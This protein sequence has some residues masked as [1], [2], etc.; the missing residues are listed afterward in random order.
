MSKTDQMCKEFS[1]EQNYKQIRYLGRNQIYIDVWY[2]VNDDNLNRFYFIRLFQQLKLIPKIRTWSW[3]PFQ[4]PGADKNFYPDWRSLKDIY[5]WPE[6]AARPPPK[7][8]QTCTMWGAMPFILLCCEAQTP[9]FS[10]NRP[11]QP[12][13]REKWVLMRKKKLHL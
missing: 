5:L 11:L 8:S 9:N 1:K 13:N 6:W 12:H 3:A 4:E 7:K 10:H 2:Y